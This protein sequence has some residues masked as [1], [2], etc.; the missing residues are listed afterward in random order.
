MGWIFFFGKFPEKKIQPILSEQREIWRLLKIKMDYN[1][2]HLV[3]KK[4]FKEL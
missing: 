3:E 1:L 2:E 4:D